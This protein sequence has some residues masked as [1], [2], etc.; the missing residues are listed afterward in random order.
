MAAVTVRS[1]RDLTVV[2]VVLADTQPLY[3]VVRPQSALM[4]LASSIHFRISRL[5]R[6]SHV[7]EVGE[8]PEHIFP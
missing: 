6:R 4:S 1:I 5:T 8:W 2:V 7:G 3:Y